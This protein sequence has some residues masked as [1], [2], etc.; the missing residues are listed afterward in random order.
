MA[1]ADIAYAATELHDQ[2]HS[3]IDSL[4]SVAMSFALDDERL[5]DGVYVRSLRKP[6]M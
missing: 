6:S 2:I 3:G 4:V 1:I 5:A